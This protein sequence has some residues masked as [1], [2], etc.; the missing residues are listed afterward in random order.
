MKTT[1][2][3]SFQD[4]RDEA[5][6]AV[7]QVH[8]IVTAYVDPVEQTAHAYHLKTTERAQHAQDY[9]LPG[10]FAVSFL[11]YQYPHLSKHAVRDIVEDAAC[12][13]AAEMDTERG[14]VMAKHRIAVR[15]HAENKEAGEAIALAH[16]YHS[17]SEVHA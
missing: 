15:L 7:E 17:I 12:Y 8:Q 14:R 10:T 5:A 3:I 1:N 11:P 16:L 13:L 2:V 6:H 9:Q 4:N